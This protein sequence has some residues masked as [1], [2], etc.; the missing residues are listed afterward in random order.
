MENAPNSLSL[1]IMEALYDRYQQN[2]QSV[3]ADW[4]D[5]F[6]ACNGNGAGDAAIRNGGF[7]RRPAIQA[8]SRAHAQPPPAAQNARNTP[9]RKSA[10][11][12]EAELERV[13]R[14]IAIQHRVD[15]LIRNIRVRG[16]IVTR[17]D[18]LGKVEPEPAEITPFYYGLTEEDMEVPVFSE[19]PTPGGVPLTVRK[20]ITRFRNTYCRF[21]GCQFMHIDDLA[22]R[23]WLQK[24]MEGTENRIK[25]D[26]D[27]QVRIL[28]RL[29]DAVILEEF[30]QKKYI[31]AKSFSLEGAETLIPLLE[32]AIEKSATLGHEEILIG[33]PHRGRL[34][35][36]CNIMGKHPRRI[37]R[38]FEDRDTEEFI[39]RG[40]VKYHQGYHSDWLTPGGQRV[41]LALAFNPSHLEFVG[42]VVQGRM[43]ARHDREHDP[44]GRKGI[45]YLVH[46][47]AA[48]AGEG[49]VQETL[50]LSELAGYNSGGTLH[51]IVNN[52][53][54]FTT[55]P[56]DARSCTYATDVAKMLQIP[57]FHVN[58]EEPESVAQAVNLALD[59]RNT[60]HRD[61]VIDMY[62]YRKRGHNEGDE[63]GFTQPVL[64]NE[65]A[66]R[67]TV[68]EGY[69][70][71][72]LK[73]GGVT[74]EEADE[75]AER[76]RKMLESELDVARSGAAFPR[77]DSAADEPGR[78]ANRLRELWSLFKGGP[79]ADV[80]EVETAVEQGRLRQLLERLTEAPTG[81]RVNPRLQQRFLDPRRAMADGERPLDWAAGEALAY[82]TLLTNDGRRVRLSGQ[83]S[84]RGTF[85]HR[86]AVWHD[87]HSG[88][89]YCPFQHLAPDQAPFDVY[90][91]PLSEAG[92]VGFEYG[93]SVG[94]PH[95]LTI[96]EAQ[97]GD[98]SNVAQV[99]FDQFIASAEDKWKRLTGLVLLLPHGLEGTGPEHASGRIE[100]FLT[101][102]ADDNI[103]IAQPTTPANF[104]HLLRRQVLRPWRKPLVVY[105]PK[106]MLRH[107][108]AVSPL[109]D[110]AEGA[111]QRFI[112]D[113]EVNPAEARRVLLCSGKIYYDLL[114]KRR[115]S[116][117]RDVAIIRLEQL[118]P[119]RTQ[120]WE[121]ALSPYDE[122]IDVV[123]VQEEPENSGAWRWL[124]AQHCPKLIGRFPLRGVT[125]PA[126][127]SPA[128]GSHN[129]HKIEQERL[130][131]AAFA[132]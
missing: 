93:Y 71:H 94:A 120:H 69:L 106:S 6:D 97:F 28:T 16:H 103:Q 2:P 131:N 118:Y 40:D 90:N 29:T 80:P 33:M 88:D 129:A 116:G 86:H 60:F 10:T 11:S 108:E 115:D 121:A 68:R 47:D 99:Y 122:E 24:R 17:V 105:T 119:L 57:I 87:I 72:L 21:I 113:N 13:T 45:V 55:D 125:R 73:M 7:Q 31:G 35:V 111:F 126:S 84:Q 41:H 52:Q 96:W 123:W 48:F 124:R 12:M 26:R 75:I 117:R 101:L 82:A 89:Q 85:S 91:S 78:P 62:C 37:F 63:P 127:A 59:F 5:Y 20:I 23:E 130:V 77:W 44:E 36:L 61:V 109:K 132:N 39:G 38:E 53:I 43:R 3:A 19:R 65:I 74:K 50:N 95:S 15:K 58:G 25:L 34:N 56:N 64:Y 9:T 1:G 27:Q 81:F 22:V 14:Q 114:A 128:T 8:P 66:K 79:E 100:R 67:R 51:I 83:D 4:R 76:R 30:I 42:P 98:F 102:A 46:G 54:G 107:P 49:I 92:V 32:I 112:A 104:F 70:Q 110:L 18:P